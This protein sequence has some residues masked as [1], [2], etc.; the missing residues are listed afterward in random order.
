HPVQRRD[1]RIDAVVA[2]T[3]GLKDLPDDLVHLVV[4]QRFVRRHPCRDYDGQHDVTEVLAG[5]LA[6]HAPDRLDD[7]H[8][9]VARRE[10]EHRIKSWYVHAFTEAAYVAQDAAGVGRRRRL[11]P[12]ELGFLFAGVHPAIDVLRL[13][14][15]RDRLLLWGRRLLISLDD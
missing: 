1:H 8:L 13:A 11:E 5:R 7:V 2:R 14:L 10:E 6:H 3:K 15:E 4:V 12:G 9:R